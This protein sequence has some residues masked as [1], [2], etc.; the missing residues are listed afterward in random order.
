MYNT[1]RWFVHVEIKGDDDWVK[2]YTRMAVID[3]E[4]GQGMLVKTLRDN[5]I[6]CAPSP[7]D[8]KDRSLW[9]GRIHGAQWPPWVNLDLP[10]VFSPLA[11]L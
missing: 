11:V 3:Q 4:I 9:R 1:F 7:V 5:T 2:S 8:A 10:W 6:R